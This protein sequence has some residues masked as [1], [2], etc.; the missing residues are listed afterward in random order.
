M[1]L[2]NTKIRSLFLLPLGLRANLGGRVQGVLYGRAFQSP[3]QYG[4][5]SVL[6]PALA[7]QVTQAM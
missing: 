3:F 5:L 2:N 1:P 7:S 6:S 4:W